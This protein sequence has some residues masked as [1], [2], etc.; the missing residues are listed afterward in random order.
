MRRLKLIILTVL[1]SLSGVGGLGLVYSSQ[2]AAAPV[3][4]V[5]DSQ[6]DA[7]N[8]LS[9]LGGTGCGGGAQTTVGKVINTV[10][11]IISV[12]LGAVGVIM[13]IVARIQIHH[14]GR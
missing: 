12:V 13:V 3:Y 9:Q 2:A 1:V 6:S 7:C 4:L 14:L 5:A 10:V 11:R 8:G